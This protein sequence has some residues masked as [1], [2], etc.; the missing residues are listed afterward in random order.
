[1]SMIRASGTYAQSEC[2]LAVVVAVVWMLLVV[3]LVEIKKQVMCVASTT[4]VM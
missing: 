3:V 4:N 2:L 1:M